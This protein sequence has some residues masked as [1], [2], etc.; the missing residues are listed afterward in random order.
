MDL[1]SQNLLM[2][3]GG[4]QDPTYVD[5]V[6][7]TYLYYG[8][9]PDNNLNTTQTITNGIDLAG[10]GGLVWLK[11]RT[12]LL[13]SAP[14]ALVDT[15]RGVNKTI[16]SNSSQAQ[17]AYDDVN[18]FNSNGFQLKGQGNAGCSNYGQGSTTT[19]KYSSWTFRKQKG[20]FDVV[21]YT[22]GS[23]TQ[24]ISHNLGCLPG[25]I[26]VKALDSS[27]N[28][29]VFHRDMDA[30][31][32]NN[33][34]MKLNTTDGRFTGAG[35]N[36]TAT[37]FDAAFSLTNNDGAD[38]IAYLFAGGESN[39]ATARSV[40][41]DDDDGLNVAASSDFNFG[42]G[43][44]CIECWVY[45]DDLPGSGSPSYGRVFQLDGP[46][47]N[48]AF[49]NLQVT[50][51]PGNNTLHAWAYGGGN[52][53]AI[54]GSKNLKDGQWHHIA[55]NRDS[56]NLITQYVDGIPDGTVT[57]ATN[58][59]P[60]SG[61][62]RPRIGIYDTGGTNGVF[63]GKISNL[64]VTVGEPVY[65][66]AFRPSTTPLTTSSQGVTASNVKLLCC[67]DPTNMLGATETPSAI[68]VGG[69]NPVVSSSHPF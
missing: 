64:R 12:G 8:N 43:Q 68:S 21:K 7:S 38:F 10:E 55:V 46:T 41:I 24:T 59:N 51:N 62:P 65:T 6:F 4:K 27:D 61:S 31:N 54:V 26:I 44:F 50:I 57:T 34:A 29:A 30:T 40:D 3:S 23:G 49:S 32:P 67:N 37:T 13:G 33:Y 16:Y 9:C 20:F 18:A 15:E 25:M 22:G 53:V 66:S 17:D 69:G 42:T 52:P 48:S 1:V 39:A 35:W 45:V 63:N 60:N 56:N 58:F 19:A 11:H 14:H 47:G 5:D 2:T 36:V 28:W